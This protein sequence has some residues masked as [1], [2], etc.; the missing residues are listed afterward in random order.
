MVKSEL[1]GRKI[2]I[3]VLLALLLNAC[4]Q[5]RTAEYFLLHP[6]EVQSTYQ[7]CFNQDANETDPLN[8]YLGLKN[9]QQQTSDCVALLKVLSVL[10]NNS[11][12]LINDPGLFGLNIMHGQMALVQLQES[13]RGAVKSGQPQEVVAHLKDQIG[14]QK[15]QI[16]G[17]YALI[18]LMN[19]RR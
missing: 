12:E 11:A 19:Q 16:E 5:K 1:R 17:R 6:E 10:K 18:R 4:E 7:R 8:S 9:V 13:Y 15:L 14:L 2:C 3:F